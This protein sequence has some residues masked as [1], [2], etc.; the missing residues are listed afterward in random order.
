MDSRVGLRR[1]ASATEKMK[2][3]DVSD[4]PLVDGP[5]SPQHH[6]FF[7]FDRCDNS[8]ITNPVAPKSFAVAD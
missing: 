6:K 4:R 8:V 2:E 3:V 7:V 5:P 1:Q